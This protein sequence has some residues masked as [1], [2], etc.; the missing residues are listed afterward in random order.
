MKT[1]HRSHRNLNRQE[2]YK[3][4]EER[5]KYKEETNPRIMQSSETHKRKRRLQ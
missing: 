3:K 2:R 4:N 5:E 1:N